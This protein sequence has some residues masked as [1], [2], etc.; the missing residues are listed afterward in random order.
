MKGKAMPDDVKAAKELDGTKGYESPGRQSSISALMAVD[1]MCG[2]GLE[3]IAEES[4]E[5]LLHNIDLECG[6]CGECG[7]CG[8]IAGAQF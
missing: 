6:H 8:A 1:L 3:S 7:E 2:V 4:V 5:S